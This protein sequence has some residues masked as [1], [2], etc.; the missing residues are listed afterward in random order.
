M[1]SESLAPASLKPQEL[2]AALRDVT[3]HYRAGRISYEAWVGVQRCLLGENFT[4]PAPRMSFV[5]IGTP[6]ASPATQLS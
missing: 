1:P 6:V 4:T 5:P 3:Y 2:I